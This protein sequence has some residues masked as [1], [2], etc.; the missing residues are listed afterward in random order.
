MRVLTGEY[1]RLVIAVLMTLPMIGVLASGKVWDFGD[2]KLM[3]VPEDTRAVCAITE[4]RQPEISVGR[5]KLEGYQNCNL[6]QALDISGKNAEGERLPVQLVSLKDRNGKELLNREDAETASGEMM[7]SPGYYDLTM[8]AEE[9][10][11]GVA[12]KTELMYRFTVD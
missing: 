3:D 12:Y 4:R 2:I 10:Y 8:R 11:Q 5:D 9:T 1:G 6:M 7:F